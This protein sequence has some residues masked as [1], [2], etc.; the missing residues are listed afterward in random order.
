MPPLPAVPNVIRMRILWE[1]QGKSNQG[2]RMFISYSGGP[3]A[4]SDLTAFANKYITAW[5]TN[6]PSL[7]NVDQTFLGVILEDL[8]SATG[9]VAEVAASVVGTRGSNVLP[10]SAAIVV[11]FEI[12][13][14]YRGGHPR[15]YWPLGTSE[16][17]EQ[18]TGQFTETFQSAVASAV[19]AQTDSI[20][21][22]TS[23]STTTE[24]QVN[25]S[26][27]DGFTAIENPFTG[28]YRNVPKLR[29]TPLV[30]DIGTIVVRSYI[31]SQRRRR[32]KTSAS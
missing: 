2:Q 12:A 24:S 32:Q 17:T 27:Y 4:P 30:D 28:R 13:R 1:I 6:M 31:A 11:S 14:R 8:S 22:Q 29:A 18:G 7:Y 10:P 23:G 16:D 3:P 25:V 15:S 21:A 26:Y 9:A 19:S 5:N 20:L